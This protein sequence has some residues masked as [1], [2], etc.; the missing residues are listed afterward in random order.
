[1]ILCAGEALIDMIPNADGA[2]VPHVGGAVLNTAV[3]LGRLGEDVGLVTG[4]SSDPFGAMIEDHLRASQVSVDHAVRSDRNTALAFV[5][6]ENGNATYTFYDDAT[7][8]RNI[9][10]IDIASVPAGTKAVFFGGISLCNPPVADSLLDLALSQPSDRLVMAD[11]NIRPGFVSDHDG[12]RTRL[13]KLIGRADI[14][15]LS[16]DDIGWLVPDGDLNAKARTVLDL[17]PKM[18]LL[19]EGGDG[20]T[21]HL[22]NGTMVRAPAQQAQV[23]DTVGAGDTFNAGCLAALRRA[24]ALHPAAIETLNEAALKDMLSLAARAAAITVS[25]AGANPPWQEELD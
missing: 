12:Y 25:R 10:P 17:G 15:K 7:A 22:A 20:A 1:M 24:D 23:V 5:H 3:A 6:L 18:L 16:D 19:T 14:V 9:Q 13:T 2:Y 8:T 21:A 4:L 11:P